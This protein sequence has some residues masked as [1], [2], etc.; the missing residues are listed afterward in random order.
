MS[1]LSFNKYQSFSKIGQSVGLLVGATYFKNNFVVTPLGIAGSIIG[2]Y[3]SMPSTKLHTRDQALQIKILDSH[4][5]TSFL[6][7]LNPLDT[8]FN[9]YERDHIAKFFNIFRNIF[10]SANKITFDNK[11]ISTKHIVFDTFHD[12]D[13]TSVL[14]DI[15]PIGIIGLSNVI[16]KNTSLTQ[17]CIDL[18]ITYLSRPITNYILFL[19]G[20]LNSYEEI[21]L[22][23]NSKEIK[24]FENVLP[25]ELFDEIMRVSN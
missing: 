21:T 18:S 14:C 7:G 4:F 20:D 2:N 9:L 11:V 17:N 8:N 6:E 24:D 3:F 19:K 15:G 16:N 22:D 12:A 10:T 25:V 23:Y 5:S 1:A 13:L